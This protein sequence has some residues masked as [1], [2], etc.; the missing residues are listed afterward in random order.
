MKYPR[1]TLITNLRVS[2]VICFKL[3]RIFLW[4]FM[5]YVAPSCD[6]PNYWS[7][8]VNISISQRRL[9]RG[10]WNQ[11]LQSG[12]SAHNLKFSLSFC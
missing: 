1:T 2:E 10:F 3:V 9:D 7:G 6:F 8:K 5:G 11:V 4:D 12:G